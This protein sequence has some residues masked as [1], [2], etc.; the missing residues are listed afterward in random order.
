M[1]LDEK[2][3]V[4]PFTKKS[5]KPEVKANPEKKDSKQTNPSSLV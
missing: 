3:P 1:V 5:L 2:V 4:L